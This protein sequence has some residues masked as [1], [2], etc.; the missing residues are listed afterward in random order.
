MARHAK[1]VVIIRVLFESVTILLLQT[2]TQL[3]ASIA[4]KVHPSNNTFGSL[5]MARA[6]PLVVFAHPIIL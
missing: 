3:L 4:D 1:I 5:T 6:S 2:F